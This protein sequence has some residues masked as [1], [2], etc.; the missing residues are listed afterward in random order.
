MICI[1]FQF[2]AMIIYKIVC[3]LQSSTNREFSAVQFEEEVSIGWGGRRRQQWFLQTCQWQRRGC[4]NQRKGSGDV[5]LELD[6][7]HVSRTENDKC[8]ILYLTN[9]F[10][11]L[12][13]SYSFVE[14]MLKV[15]SGILSS[16][17]TG[18]ILTYFPSL[19]FQD[20]IL[21]E[22]VNI[23]PSTFCLS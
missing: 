14:F 1:F 21:L 8:I 2:W 17:C 10:F 18:W 7:Y 11:D 23:S 19:I 9:G 6:S 22:S 3:W 5:Y 13:F 20:L 16:L 15:V 4:R 12:S